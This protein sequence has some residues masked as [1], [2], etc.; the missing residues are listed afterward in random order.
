MQTIQPTTFFISL[1]FKKIDHSLGHQEE[2]RDQDNL[3]PK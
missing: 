1:I 3:K 2:D